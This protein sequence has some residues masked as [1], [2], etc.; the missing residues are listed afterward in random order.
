[1]QED[2]VASH[3]RGPE[4]LV[5]FGQPEHH[6]EDNTWSLWHQFLKTSTGLGVGS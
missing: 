6:R 4:V 1:M 3:L 2:P 5:E